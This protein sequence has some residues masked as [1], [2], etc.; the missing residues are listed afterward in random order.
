MELVPTSLERPY[1]PIDEQ[2]WTKCEPNFMY[3]HEFDLNESIP[4]LC[5]TDLVYSYLRIRSSKSRLTTALAFYLKRCVAKS[6]HGFVFTASEPENDLEIRFTK[7]VDQWRRETW[8]M[9]SVKRRTSN[10]N[11]LSII[12][13]GRPAI[14]LILKELERL[15]DHWFLALRVLAD[16]DPAKGS[17]D[18]NESREAWIRWGKLKGYL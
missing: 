13:L 3:S 6:L 15:G 10:V 9:S 2:S 14:P 16:E 1:V 8:F 4:I 5:D 11:Y 12:S 18:F 7:Y 17:D